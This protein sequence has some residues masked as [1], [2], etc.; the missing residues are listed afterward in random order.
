V[1][2]DASSLKETEPWFQEFWSERLWS[3]KGSLEEGIVNLH[4]QRMRRRRTRIAV[5]PTPS[6]PISLF[7]NTCAACPCQNPVMEAL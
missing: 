2:S 3:L 1:W 5:A 6:A 4:S 7:Y